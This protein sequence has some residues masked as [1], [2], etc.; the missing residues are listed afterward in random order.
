MSSDGNYSSLYPIYRAELI[1][2]ETELRGADGSVPSVDGNAAAAAAADG[3]SIYSIYK[4]YII[5]I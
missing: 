2:Q 3:K 5:M 1:S 4:Q